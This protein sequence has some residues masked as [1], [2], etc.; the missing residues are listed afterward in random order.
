VFYSG[1]PAE[2]GRFGG[3]TFRKDPAGRP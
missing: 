1:N 3:I 2:T